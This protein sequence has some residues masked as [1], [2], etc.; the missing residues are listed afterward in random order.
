[1]VDFLGVRGVYVL[2][3][4]MSCVGCCGVLLCY[5]NLIV[6]VICVC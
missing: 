4:R 2:F 3:C 6:V 1:M 5:N